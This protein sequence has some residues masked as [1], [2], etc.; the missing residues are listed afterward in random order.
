MEVDEE[1]FMTLDAEGD[2]FQGAQNVL[3]FAQVWN[4]VW[5]DQETEK[6]D[7]TLTLTC[8]SRFEVSP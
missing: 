3:N 7:L 6:H 4:Q 5:S 1:G 8:G 2:A